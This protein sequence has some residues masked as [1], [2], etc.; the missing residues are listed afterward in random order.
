MWHCTR[1]LLFW[2]AVRWTG[3][4]SCPGS[5]LSHV[6]KTSP[7]AR[8]VLLPGSQFRPS[9]GHCW[10][11]RHCPVGLLCPLQATHWRMRRTDLSA[12]ALWG[13][14]DLSSSP[15]FLTTWPWASAEL[16]VSYF[17]SICLITV[18]VFVFLK[19]WWDNVCQMLT[20]GLGLIA[21]Q[22]LFLLYSL[23]IWI[24]CIIL[25]LLPIGKTLS[26]H[27]C[28]GEAVCMFFL[29]VYTLLNLGWFG[30]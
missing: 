10:R 17:S 9:W 14:A 30:G 12:W 8:L 21:Y 2:I 27:L 22:P 5:Q 24:L 25:Q 4:R 18:L 20:K 3:E 28:E 19:F 6:A 26:P 29:L 23:I 11:S 13:Q 7:A 16:S 1:C 15:A